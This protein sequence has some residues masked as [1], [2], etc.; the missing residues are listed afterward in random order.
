MIAQI[1]QTFHVLPSVVERDL[2]EDPELTAMECVKLLS[3]R[4]LFQAWKSAKD[5]NKFLEQHGNSKGARA[6]IENDFTIANERRNTG[7][8]VKTQR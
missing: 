5:E 4:D 7:S 2:D 1:A 8:V 6:V 3:Y